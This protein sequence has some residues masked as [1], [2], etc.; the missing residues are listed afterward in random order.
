MTEN[1]TIRLGVPGD[2]GEIMELAKLSTDENAF[3]APDMGKIASAIW[4][5]LHRDKGL[6]GI[7]TSDPSRIEGVVILHIG[8]MWYAPSDT[9]I[10]E[11]K[12]IFIHPEYRSAKGGRARKL[13][14]FSKRVADEL[15][16]PLMIGV[17][18]NHR[19]KGKVRM[20]EREFGD[21]VGCFWLYNASTGAPNGE[22]TH[23]GEGVITSDIAPAG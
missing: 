23:E 5:A 9:P 19:T 18:S 15:Q 12:V 17:M 21:S 3:M 22:W 14:Q 8:E 1:L 6:V 4:P 13:C 2:L 16:I 20:Y 10:L 11:E 7:I